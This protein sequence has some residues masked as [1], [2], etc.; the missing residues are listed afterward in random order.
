MKRFVCVMG[1]VIVAVSVLGQNRKTEAFGEIFGNV[2]EEMEDGAAIKGVEDIADYYGRLVRN[3]LNVNKASRE[4]L[5][6]LCLLTD[7]QIAS[8][9]EYR[10]NHGAVL[11]ATELQLVNGFEKHVVELLRP[12]IGFGE[13]SESSVGG[14]YVS[15][16]LLKWS[17]RKPKDELVGEPFYSRIKYTGEIAGKLRTG[18]QL[19]KDFG[20]KTFA[21]GRMPLGDFSS[22]YVMAEDVEL[23]NKLA[24]KE[25]LLGDYTARFGQGLVV[26]NAFSFGGSGGSNLQGTYKRGAAIVPYGSADESRFFRGGAVSL[27]RKLG[28]FADLE[29]TGFFSLKRVD[30]SIKDGKYTSLPDDGLHNTEAS[31]TKRKTL[32]EMV[33]GGNILLRLE[34]AKVGLN[35]VGYGFDRHNGRRVQ[36]YSKYQMYDGMYGNFSVDWSLLIGK[37]RGFGEFAVDYGMQV[38]FLCGAQM[39][40]GR[41]E[42]SL[43]YRN[44]SRGYIAPY[45][46]A[47]SSSGSCSN[48]NGVS[49]VMQRVISGKKLSGGVDFT[50]YPWKRFNMDTASYTNRI[51]IKSEAINESGSWN[52]KFYGKWGS[53][54]EAVKLGIKG[55]FGK[56]LGRLFELKF[57]GEAVAAD[58]RSAGYAVSALLRCSLW[59]DRLRLLINGDY[60]NCMEWDCRIYMYEYDLP[61]SYS[62]SLMY[63]RGFGW[64]S[65]LSCILGRN[66]TVYVKTDGEYEVKI[67]LKMRFF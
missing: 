3:P 47:I 11:S 9:L 4:D 57:R 19:E 65:M 40:L 53:G 56:K 14:R 36:E 1:S 38:A 55:M 7:F 26:W 51:W 60:H 6:R 42:T 20:E 64:Y 24:I 54:G 18:F 50:Y 2:L 22:F 43:V 63:G 8:L 32:R 67:G 28:R 31:L 10:K 27:G 30:A 41:L 49:L 52:M 48:Q 15:G 33:Y 66:C 29:C 5:E 13:G 21:K 62:S 12:F 25:L 37:V 34:K 35:Y 17:S 58:F 16:L 23:G 59:G 46:G 45:A 44:Y 39:R 61:Q